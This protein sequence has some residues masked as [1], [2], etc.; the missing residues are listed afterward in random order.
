MFPVFRSKSAVG[1]EMPGGGRNRL[2]YLVFTNFRTS[3]KAVLDR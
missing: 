3:Q 2:K 1:P